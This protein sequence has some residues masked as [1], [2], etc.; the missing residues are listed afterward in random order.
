MTSSK[1]EMMWLKEL[2]PQN[3]MSNLDEVFTSEDIASGTKNNH[4]SVLDLIRRYRS[5]LESLGQVV[6]IRVPTSGLDREVFHLSMCQ[7]VLIISYMKNSPRIRLFKNEV[8]KKL[9]GIDS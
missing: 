8:V 4:K 3:F 9:F 7:T 1:S 6:S 5:D 2:S